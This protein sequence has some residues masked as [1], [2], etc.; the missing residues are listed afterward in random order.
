M[1]DIFTTSYYT[2]STPN[3]PHQPT[4]PP[5]QDTSPIQHPDSYQ[6]ASIQPIPYNS[7]LPTANCQPQ[8][9]PQPAQPV[10][11]LTA[12]VPIPT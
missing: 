1:V 6:H 11:A 5:T 9:Q 12:T 7:Q 10:K 8:P 3:T 4:H 2:A